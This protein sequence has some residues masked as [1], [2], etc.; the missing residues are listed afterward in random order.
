L[1]AATLERVGTDA[2]LFL[3]ETSQDSESR[4]HLQRLEYV[5]LYLK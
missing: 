3:A 5:P 1:N 2:F 4:E